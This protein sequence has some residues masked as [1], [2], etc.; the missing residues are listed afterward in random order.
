MEERTLRIPD[1]PQYGVI[2]EDPKNIKNSLFFDVYQNAADCVKKIITA[3]E[4]NS[5][6]KK[7]TSHNTNSFFREEFLNTV[8]SFT[9][10]RGSGK[11]SGMMTFAG[12]LKEST[13]VG[14]WEPIEASM[15]EKRFWTLRAIDS[16]HMGQNERL[17]TSISSRLYQEYKDHQKDRLSRISIDKK[18]DFLQII[19][20]VNKLS[21]MFIQGEWT[22]NEAFLLQNSTELASLRKKVQEMVKCFL[23]MMFGECNDSTYLVISIDDLDMNLE[24][25]FDLVD[26]IRKF[27]TIKHVIVLTSVDIE[28]LKELVCRHFQKPFNGGT[29]NGEVI[30]QMYI[31]KIFPITRQM[32]M[33]KL[34]TEQLGRCYIDNLLGNGGET[35]RKSLGLP[36]EES[37]GLSTE[38][39]ENDKGKKIYPK[40]LTISEGVLHLVYRK[41]MLLLVP[42]DNGRH[43]LI[44][45]NLRELCNFI[46]LLQKMDDVA[47][48]G[49]TLVDDKKLLE[50][51]RIRYIRKVSAIQ[52]G[53]ASATSGESFPG[54]II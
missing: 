19:Q 22:K 51:Q 29:N 40:K 33:P 20:E 31:E 26:D 53:T 24:N 32:Q 43:W 37:R 15:I 4:L 11:S 2:V 3:N 10:D 13:T 23:E 50:K 49:D 9:G 41:T 54:L 27:L 5:D 42:E 47:F 39:K 38:K 6:D 36:T 17:L 28:Q 25:S 45:H 21:Y 48:D 18:R 52:T 1:N 7:S 30:G 12:L 8:I 34:S 46:Y 16:T 35:T 14:V 44:P